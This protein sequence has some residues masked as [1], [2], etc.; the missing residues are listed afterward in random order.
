MV[1]TTISTTQIIKDSNLLQGG[2]ANRFKE[3]KK[4]KK[5][6]LV[7]TPVGCP[8]HLKMIVLIVLDMVVAFHLQ[9]PI[10]NNNHWKNYHL[11]RSY[12]DNHSLSGK[13]VLNGQSHCVYGYGNTSEWSVPLCVDMGAHLNG[14][15]H[16]ACGYAIVP[17]AL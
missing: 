16:C 17:Q 1:I 6:R 8:S 15:S 12:E 3:R 10:S 7:W 2:M 13:P 9:H 4:R 14:Q 5:K 11:Y